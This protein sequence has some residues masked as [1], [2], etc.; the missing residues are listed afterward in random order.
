VTAGTDVRDGPV[1]D[2]DVDDGGS[3]AGDLARPTVVPDAADIEILGA[4]LPLDE[5]ALRSI[6]IFLLGDGPDVVS[7][8]VVVVATCDVVVDDAAAAASGI[9]DDGS[10]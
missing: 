3:V 10:S 4:V 2:D 8:V 5:G 1:I 6:L 9:T 7:S